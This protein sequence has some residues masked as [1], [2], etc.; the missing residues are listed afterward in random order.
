MAENR[1]QPKADRRSAEDVTCPK[2]GEA[3]KPPA[4]SNRPPL[5]AAVTAVLVAA[6]LPNTWVFWIN[7]PWDMKR[8]AVVAIFP[9]SPAGL[10][11]LVAQVLLGLKNPWS[12]PFV[13]AVS[14]M[15]MIFFLWAFIKLSRRTWWLL[16]SIYT[17][18][19]I[20]E[21]FTAYVWY[22]AFMKSSWPSSPS[23]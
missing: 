18:L 19:F 21:I 4:P 9:I 23:P 5:R 22:E 11:A 15:L 6:Y 14:V 10:P 1:G 2:C 12:A 13:I 16:L 17:L 3:F 20:Y 8:A 7:Q